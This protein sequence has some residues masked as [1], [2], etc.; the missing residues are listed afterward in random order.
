MTNVQIAKLFNEIADFL[1]MENA[2]FKPAAYRRAAFGI[3]SLQKDARDIYMHGGLSAFEEILGVGKDLALKMEEFITTGK[4]K[5][6]EEL[7]K[8]TPVDVANLTRI[9]G[10]GAKTVKKLYEG[11]KIATVED[12]EKA[13]KAGKI[14]T[15]EGFDAKKEQNF[16]NGIV[17]LKKEHGRMLLF[18]ANALAF[19][20]KEALVKRS[21]VKRVEVVGSLRRMKETIGDIDLLAISHDPKK[22]A[23]AFA[24][25]ENVERVYGRG[26]SKVNV[27]FRNGIDGDLRIFAPEEFGAAMQYF[28]G[29]KEHNIKTR[30][31]AVKKGLKLNEYGLFK[32]KKRVAGKDEREIYEKLGLA[33]IEPE[34]REDTGEIEA[35]LKGKLPKII[36]YDALKGDL[37]V[38][39]NASDGEHSIA[40]MAEAAFDAGLS[41]IGITDHSQSL[42]IAGG[43]ERESLEKQLKE[44]DTLNKKSKGEF[45]ILKSAEIDI[46]EDGSLDMPEDLLALLDYALVTVHTHFKMSEHEMTQRIIKALSHP[47]VDIL[48]HPTGRLVMKRPPYQVNMERMIE[49]AK[50]YGVAL[51]IN[52]YPERLDLKDAHIRNAR[53]AGA[54]FVISS[55]A[56][57]KNHFPV[58]RFGLA[59]ARRGWVEKS[60]VLNTLPVKKFLK[61]LRRNSKRTSL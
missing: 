16:L 24:A 23:E 43:L 6:L 15:L 41:Y 50:E 56:H 31:L 10:I 59:Q 37:Q 34:M 40:Q 28:T 57:N 18:E 60:D 42:K 17:F 27:R 32:G 53:E 22:T 13:A 29:S 30:T 14:R 1:E 48:G 33:Y 21:E 2:P 5:A 9:E 36:P 11:L 51:E 58:L 61:A 45:R 47:L 38:Q 54:K 26:A 55:D 35:A 19:A 49:A 4:V 52:A 20:L 46:L 25:F 3:E 12:L 44:I 8:K 7:R 39:T